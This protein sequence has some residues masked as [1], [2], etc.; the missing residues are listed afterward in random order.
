[1]QIFVPMWAEARGD[2]AATARK[3]GT[4]DSIV[5]GEANARM[6]ERERERDEGKKGKKECGCR[7]G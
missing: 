3:T 1:M 5:R 6:D 4:D 2:K 7:R